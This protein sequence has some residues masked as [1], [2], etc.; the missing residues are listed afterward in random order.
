MVEQSASHEAGL[1]P[2]T[3]RFH[4]QNDL[5]IV[6]CSNCQVVSVG[7]LT[8]ELASEGLWPVGDAK[9][10]HQSVSNL[11][12]SLKN[13]ESRI[14]LI[15]DFRDEDEEVWVGMFACN[16]LYHMYNRL[17]EVMRKTRNGGIVGEIGNVDHEIN[18]LDLQMK[19]A[20]A[21]WH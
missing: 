8:R 10:Y 9:H 5:N 17:L 1:L 15:A 3:K 2:N 6:P 20:Q 12:L 14:R 13:A 4:L 7:R 21:C 11:L 19:N 16:T 18:D